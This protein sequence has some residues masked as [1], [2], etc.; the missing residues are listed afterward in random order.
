MSERPPDQCASDREEYLE[1]LHIKNRSSGCAVNQFLL[2]GFEN[3]P[4]PSAIL[5]TTLN[6]ALPNWS[7]T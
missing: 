4:E 5:S 7:F 1:W 2:S 3:F 6:E